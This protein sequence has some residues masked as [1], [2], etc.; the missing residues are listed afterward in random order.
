MG[1]TAILRLLVPLLMGVA[2]SS[3][4]AGEEELTFHLM[5]KDHQFRPADI[6]VPAGKRIKLIVE[7]QQ[8]LPAE[9]ESFS[10]NRE[11]VVI[12]HN[13]IV[14]Y[15]SPMAPGTYTFFDDFHRA[16]K[17]TVTAK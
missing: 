11:K 3:V 15:L 2:A 1:I 8:S 12:A 6:T 16:T 14:V 10:L 4:Q 7:N 9:F 17:G 13:K 5:L